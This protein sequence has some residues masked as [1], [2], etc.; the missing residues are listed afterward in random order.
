MTATAAETAALVTFL[1][2]RDIIYVFFKLSNKR[3]KCL[4][5]RENGKALKKVY[6]AGMLL[7]RTEGSG[8]RKHIH[9]II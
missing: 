3:E 6:L 2:N 8:F 7:K 5:V 4:H 1:Y 9:A